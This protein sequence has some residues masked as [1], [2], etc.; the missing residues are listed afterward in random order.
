MSSS[1]RRPE[2]ACL[3]PEEQRRRW[4]QI[5]DEILN[6]PGTAAERTDA[7]ANPAGQVEGVKMG[8]SC[9]SPNPS[10]DPALRTSGPDR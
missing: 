8:S 10:A 3:S 2:R 6:D 4:A 9:A 1:G 5:V 7:G